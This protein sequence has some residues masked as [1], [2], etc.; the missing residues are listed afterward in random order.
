MLTLMSFCR[1]S[2]SVTAAIPG[3][4]QRGSLSARRGAAAATSAYTAAAPGAEYTSATYN[5]Q[6]RGKKESVRH[7][8]H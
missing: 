4:D 8:N 5:C 2:T 1:L 7:Q 3:V 6:T